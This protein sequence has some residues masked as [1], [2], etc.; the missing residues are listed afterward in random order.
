[1]PQSDTSKIILAIVM[2]VIAGALFV[3]HFR[4]RETMPSLAPTTEFTNGAIQAL[5]EAFSNVTSKGWKDASAW[6]DAR[7]AQLLGKD[8][9]DILR[10]LQER[11]LV[12]LIVS[13]ELGIRI[14]CSGKDGMCLVSSTKQIAD[15]LRSLCHKESFALA[16][17]LQFQRTYQFDLVLTHHLRLRLQG[18]INDVFLLEPFFAEPCAE[19]S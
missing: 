4:N 9:E 18:Q 16:V 2:L 15:D 11:Q 10:V 17:L 19:F 7:S 5:E 13:D 12:Q 3:Y 1:M 14:C 8:G 6:T